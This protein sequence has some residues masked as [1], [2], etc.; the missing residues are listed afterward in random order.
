M[1]PVACMFPCMAE[2]LLSSLTGDTTKVASL[3]LRESAAFAFASCAWFVQWLRY[4]SL[5]GQIV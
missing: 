2:T 5:K 3:H 1:L 4:G